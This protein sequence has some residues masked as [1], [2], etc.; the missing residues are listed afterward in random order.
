[1]PVI[2]PPLKATASAGRD[3]LRGGLR[4]AHVGA[5]RD[6]HAD[7]A[8]G[9]REHRAEHEADGRRAVEEDGDQDREHDADDRDRAVLPRQVRGRALLDGAAISC[10]RALPASGQD[11]ATLHE[12]VDDSGQAAGQREVER[13]GSGY[14]RNLLFCP[15]LD[16]AVA[17]PHECGP[18]A[19]ISAGMLRE[20]RCMQRQRHGVFQR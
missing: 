20:G 16:W 11:P 3:A 19:R 7:E 1:M 14:Q 18:V 15:G 12:A 10:M 2:A 13:C 5:H 8:A 17:R 6:V 4:G 9:A